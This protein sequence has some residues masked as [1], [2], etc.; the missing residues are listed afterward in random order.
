MFWNNYPATNFHELNLDWI[1]AKVKE[2]EKI[3]DEFTVFNKLTWAGTHD[4]SKEYEK[5]SI[6][7]NSLGDGYISIK[8]V[9][10]GVTIDNEE[11]WVQ[12]ANYDALYSAFDARISE[13]ESVIGDESSGIIK[14][15]ADIENELKTIETGIDEELTRI[16]DNLDML[17]KS[18]QKHVT[19]VM[20]YY[21][22]STTGSDDNDGSSGAPFAS[23]KPFFDKANSSINGKVDLRCYITGAGTYLVPGE[24]D[25]N[26]SIL[27]QCIFHITGSVPGVTLKFTTTS[28]KVKIYECH[29]NFDNL[30]LTVPDTGADA[31]KCI[32][33]DGG[34]VAISNCTFTHQVEFYA[35]QGVVSG[36]TFPNLYASYSNLYLTS[37]TITN[38]SPDVDAYTLVCCQASFGGSAPVTELTSN[39]NTNAFIKANNSIINWKPTF[40]SLTN[41]YGY[42][43]NIELCRILC[44]PTQYNYFTSRTT[45]GIHNSSSDIG[46]AFFV[47]GS[48]NIVV[49]A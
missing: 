8:A 37:N 30:T 42:S 23:L 2:C 47:T 39:G 49:N 45:N 16:N 35:V 13:L 18:E 36:C 38:T 34:S 44:S 1:L 20:R 7:Q 40:R 28:H 29:C 14:E 21:V 31:D 12:V 46:N 41:K 5:W 26:A 43:F 15:I 32:A 25:S 24:D 33:F 19:T 9:P 10:S 27:S 48:S 17:N 22:N 6:V 3:V 11:F 4:P